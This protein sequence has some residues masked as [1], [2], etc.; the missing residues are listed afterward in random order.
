[1]IFIRSIIFEHFY[2]FFVGVLQLTWKFFNSSTDEECEDI[3]V[4]LQRFNFLDEN[5]TRKF[6]RFIEWWLR[7]KVGHNE[8]WLDKNKQEYKDKDPKD[9]IFKGTNRSFPS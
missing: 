6:Y 9:N 8:K 5:F 1:L 7:E 3:D 4:D 2:F